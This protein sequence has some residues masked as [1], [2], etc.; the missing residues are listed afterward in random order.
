MFYLLSAH[1]QTD[2]RHHFFR[3]EREVVFHN[4]V[5]IRR[6]LA[7]DVFHAPTLVFAEHEDLLAFIVEDDLAGEVGV[8]R[9]TASCRWSVLAICFP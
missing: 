2:G 8:T 6:L 1:A 4:P 5:V 7:E 3:V 9:P